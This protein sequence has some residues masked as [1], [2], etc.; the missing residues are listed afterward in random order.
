MSRPTEFRFRTTLFNTFGLQDLA[1]DLDLIWKQR[2]LITS[3]PRFRAC[4]LDRA[5]GF[6]A[7][8]I[9]PLRGARPSLGLLLTL[10]SHGQWST[11]CPECSAT[12]LICSAT[13]S[14]LSG[15]CSWQ[16]ICPGCKKIC[17]QL[18]ETPAP[19]KISFSQLLGAILQ[20][21]QEAP[22]HLRYR[23]ARGPRFDWA[24]GETGDPTPPEV[25]DPGVVPVTLPDLLRILR[26]QAPRVHEISLPDGRPVARAVSHPFRIDIDETDAT[27]VLQFQPQND[28]LTGADSEGRL[29]WDGLTLFDINRNPVFGLMTDENQPNLIAAYEA[30]G[31]KPRVIARLLPTGLAEIG[32]GSL[33][34]RTDTELPPVA[35]V[36]RLAARKNRKEISP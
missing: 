31:E 33:L 27:H 5:L 22:E 15:T 34:Y 6:S 8:Y 20:L 7:M 28:G 30:K 21:R 10:W 29:H 9:D 2:K 13:G 12:A 24:E 11:T 19:S 1:K 35:F 25:L 26:E 23:S 17:G 36:F 14:P 3:T 16:A 32:S 18:A 4:Q